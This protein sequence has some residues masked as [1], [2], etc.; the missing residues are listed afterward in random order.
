MTIIFNSGGRLG[1]AIL[2]GFI[3]KWQDKIS[4]IEEGSLDYDSVRGI[5]A[6]YE[7][8]ELEVKMGLSN[9]ALE[10]GA[11]VRL[12]MLKV[13]LYAALDRANARFRKKNPLVMGRGNNFFN[14][15]LEGVH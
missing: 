10:M 7:F 4:R 13:E 6:D 15:M 2:S 11:L 8:N 3:E 14:G 1:E 9:E 12:D 5:K